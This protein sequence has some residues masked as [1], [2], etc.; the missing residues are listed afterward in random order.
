M[1][2]LVISQQRL[3]NLQDLIDTMY[4]FYGM[5]RSS[6]GY[7][8]WEPPKPLQSE[9]APHREPPKH[10]I[11]VAG[12]QFGLALPCQPQNEGTVPRLKGHGVRGSHTTS[13]STKNA[14]APSSLEASK[15]T[16]NPVPRTSSLLLMSL[17]CNLQAPTGTDK[18]MKRCTDSPHSI[19]PLSSASTLASSTIAHHTTAMNNHD[20]GEATMASWQRRMPPEPAHHKGACS[21]RELP[22]RAS[23]LVL[24]VRLED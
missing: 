22:P 2:Y 6:L 7:T 16:S 17:N 3:T 23:R 11:S 1:P 9:N 8:H 18:K 24:G 15:H 13:Q 19:S 5:K 10:T 4:T 21:L 12:P 20:V 14:G